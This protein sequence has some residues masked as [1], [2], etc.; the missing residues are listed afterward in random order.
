MSGV[1]PKKIDI[2]KE[3]DDI[4]CDYCGFDFDREQQF[5][6]VLDESKTFCS[7]ECSDD[8]DAEFRVQE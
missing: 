7:K 2:E 5:K 4:D 3:T 1:G 6:S 8:F